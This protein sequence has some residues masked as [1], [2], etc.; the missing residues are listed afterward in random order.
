MKRFRFG[1]LVSTLGLAL[2]GGA[3]A[4]TLSVTSLTDDGPGDCSASCTL[5]DAIAT[6]VTGDTISF[7]MTGTLVLDSVKGEIGIAHDLTIT[8]SGQALTLISGNDAT[9][10]LNVTAG[11]VRITGIALI[12]GRSTG[13]SDGGGAGQN[14]G[15]GGALRVAEGATVLVRNVSLENN[16]A[17]GGKGVDGYDSNLKAGGA[18]GGAGG[19]GAFYSFDSGASGTNASGSFGGG[20]GGGAFMSTT[21]GAAGGFGGGGGGTSGGGTVGAGGTGA[22]AGGSASGNGE[23]GGGGGA[24]FGGAIYVEGSLGLLDVNFVGNEVHGGNGGR[25]TIYGGGGGG[26]A[27][28]GSAVFTRGDAITGNLCVFGAI[29]YTG[30]V[31]AGGYGGGVDLGGNGGSAGS[32]L[33]TSTGLYEAGGN[34]CSMAFLIAHAVTDATRQTVQTVTLSAEVASADVT[35]YVTFQ[36]KNSA[37][38]VIGTPVSAAVTGGKAFVFYP[39][40]GTTPGSYRVQADFDDPYGI[41]LRDS[42]TANFDIGAAATVFQ[43]EMIGAGAVC[44]AG[45]VRVLSGSDD[46]LASGIAFDGVLQTGEI[47]TTQVLCAEGKPG[48][49]AVT[50]ETKIKSGD[51]KCPYGGESIEVGLDDGRDGGTAGDGK[52]Q[53]GEVT[54]ATQVCKDAPVVAD[55]ATTGVT[56]S[57]PPKSSGAGGCASGSGAQDAWPVVILMALF[58]MRRRISNA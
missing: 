30:G 37:G 6:S 36:V 9:R 57:S 8:G 54:N 3:Q 29:T 46:G 18:G 15:E 12:H 7:D 51:K 21:S 39:L 42:A 56:V 22:G 24:G 17:I 26:G 58:W 55:Q 40:P 53:D 13:D 11:Y 31:V 5:R 44:P 27:G 43:T 25:G 52:L 34:A 47:D 10:I 28:M 20:G 19:V 4:A 2:S 41:H 49:E 50:R 1:L 23:G 16:Q 38:A 14:N 32:G 45:G 48:V 33:E 35:G